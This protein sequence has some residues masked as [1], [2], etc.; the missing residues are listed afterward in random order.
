MPEYPVSASNYHDPYDHDFDH[1]ACLKQP[2]M[3]LDP[4]TRIAALHKLA[5][6]ILNPEVYGFSVTSDVRDAA[7][8]A[9]GFT[10]VEWETAQKA[11]TEK[12]LYTQSQ[13]DAAI[14]R[15]SGK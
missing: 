12:K 11:P 3:P 10:V 1:P 8:R 15:V 4:F 13:M 9:L 5:K 14:A 7:R 2:V 6:D